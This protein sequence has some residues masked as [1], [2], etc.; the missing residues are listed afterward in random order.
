MNHRKTALQKIG[1]TWG[2]WLPAL[3]LLSNANLHLLDFLPDFIAYALLLIGMRRLAFMD[4]GFAEVARA[5]RRMLLLS[6]ARMVGL[7]WVYT[8][9]AAYEQPT[10]I[11]S[12]CFVLGVLE[13]MTILPACRQLFGSLSYLATRQ[14]GTLV[15]ESARARKISR[16]TAKLQRLEQMGGMDESRRQ[17]YDRKLRRLSRRP[18]TDVSDRVCRSCQMF[19]IVKTVFCV[20]PEF[21]S[22][23][24]ASYEAGAAR[25]NW[26][27]YINGFRALAFLAV[28]VVGIVWLSR[29][30]AYCLHIAKDTPFWERVADLCEQDAALHPER[31][32]NIQLR[33]AMILL[34]VGFVFFINLRLDGVNFVPGFVTPVAFLLALLCLRRYLPVAVSVLCGATFVFQGAVLTYTYVQT[35][36][37]FGEFDLALYDISWNVRKAYA[38]NIVGTAWPEAIVQVISLVA[39]GV[40]LFSL[41]DR[42]TKPANASTYQYTAEQL[43]RVRRTHIKCY[44]VFPAV[45]AALMI[46]AR[47][48]NCYMLPKFEMIWLADFFAAAIFAVFASLR[49]FSVKDELCPERM[50]ESSEKQ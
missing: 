43:S 27:A 17:K 30:I 33:R 26:Y 11:L 4:A 12:L 37:F 45:L 38:A 2:L 39:V 18:T 21:A 5:F 50:V 42:Y 47:L 14:D 24:Y 44:L 8:A 7:V 46:A 6:V 20:L 1:W 9:T 29:T 28:T 35:A 3:L 15:F 34:T 23:S 40:M 41:I 19:A 16:L 10:L 49:V 25:F 31:R 22:L 13:L 48:V 32:P 36:R